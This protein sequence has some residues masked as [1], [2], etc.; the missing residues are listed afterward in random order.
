MNGIYFLAGL[1]GIALNLSFIADQ[2]WTFILCMY[3]GIIVAM[4]Y[5]PSIKILGIV[6]FICSGY[7]VNYRQTIQTPLRYVEDVPKV[8]IVMS[9]IDQCQL[10]EQ[11]L[12]GVGTT[13]GSNEQMRFQVRHLSHSAYNF[14]K[15]YDG[16]FEIEA[17]YTY[18]RIDGPRNLF[19]FDMQRYWYSRGIVCKLVANSAI[20]CQQTQYQFFTINALVNLIRTWHVHLVEWFEQLPS[21]LRDY[22]ETLLLGYVRPDFYLD[23]Q[24]LS[25]MGLIHLFSISGFQVHLVCQ[26]W[27]LICRRL[28]FLKE[29]RLWSSQIILVVFWIFAGDNRSI[30]R[31]VVATGTEHFV[32]LKNCRWSRF[33]LWGITILLSL[34][35]EPGLLCHLGGQLS[36]LLS[37]GLL[38][39]NRF[40]W[41]QVSI[42]LNLLILP[43]LIWS[44]FTWHPISI[45]ANLIA[46]PCFAYV[47][48][49]LVIIGVLAQMLQLSIMVMHIDWI[50]CYIQ[51]GL[52]HIANCPGELFF[53]KPSI[54]LFGIM[55]LITLICIIYQHPRWWYCLAV[56]YAIVGLMGTI[57]TNDQVVFFDVGQG[58]AT[59][60]KLDTG[61]SVLVDVGGRVL[62]NQSEQQRKRQAIYGARP[63][64]SYLKAQAISTID[65]L[66][67]THKDADHIGNLEGLLSVY[68]IN[69]ILVPMGMHLPRHIMSKLQNTQIDSV[70]AGDTPVPGVII[71]APDHVGKGEN[72]DSIALNV[73]THGLSLILT[74][75][76]DQ[77]GEQRIL[78]Q[79]KLGPIDILKLG[80]HG[81]KTSTA[82][83]FLKR[84]NPKIG[85][86]SAGVH[87]RFGHPHAEVVARLK[88][89]HVKTYQ[90]PECGMIRVRKE[91]NVLK[92]DFALNLK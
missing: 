70:R 72:A 28:K 46:I 21:G 52:V 69:K 27:Y 87:N 74:G 6:M 16:A 68:R 14:L 10:T 1:A 15:K 88:A 31:S 61:E 63:I 17:R 44:T 65:V 82:E 80:H 91:S 83:S 23:N 58:D 38:W 53:G 92:T 71:L 9:H 67:L 77:A 34:L 42:Q 37:F 5:G 90:T 35:I 40:K 79:F 43:L 56:V 75:D 60:F 3:V 78:Q 33:D 8:K 26:V 4:Y 13:L 49:P 81:S 47:I 66:V 22:G 12:S 76:L 2:Y 89:G 86:I 25:K 85:I 29:M 48:C 18:Q 7:W 24:G 32:Q 51:K 41:W 64:V 36:C 20:K 11:G 59:F 62:F 45:L 55:G 30:I 57:R 39:F 19:E 54:V 84:L 50:I 73:I